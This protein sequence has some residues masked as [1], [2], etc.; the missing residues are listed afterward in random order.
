MKVTA[1][2]SLTGRYV[3]FQR[4]SASLSRWVSV[5][6]VYVRTTTGTAPLVV[7][8]ARFR[9]KVKARLRVRAFMPQAQVGACYV[10]GIGNVIR[11]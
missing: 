2:T 4:Y 1:A 5:T 9:A 3:L 10:A 8:S 11:S 6:R 7:T